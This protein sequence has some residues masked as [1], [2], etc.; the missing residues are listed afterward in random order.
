M[1]YFIIR[2]TDE[3]TIDQRFADAYEW[4]RNSLIAELH[5]ID[6]VFGP[7]VDAATAHERKMTVESECGE[8]CIVKFY[9]TEEER[10][11][12]RSRERLRF[13]FGEYLPVP[14]A[15]CARYE[16]RD[17]YVHLSRKTPGMIAYTQSEEHGVK[18]RQTTIRP[19]RY[20]HQFYPEWTPEA[21]DRYCGQ[22]NAN[23]L[24]L[25]ITNDPDQIVAVY[26]AEH[27]PNSC[28][29]HQANEY[30]SSIHPVYVYG[31]KYSDLALA[32]IGS[33]DTGIRARAIVWPE[34][35]IHSRIYGDELLMLALLTSKKYHKGSIAGARI[36]ALEDDDDS[37]IMPYVDGIDRARLS[38][39]GKSIIL[40][41]GPICTTNTE[42]RSRSRQR[43]PE[44]EDCAECGEQ[45]DTRSENR[46]MIRRGF[47]VC[48]SCRDDMHHECVID[49]CDSEWY[50]GDG[51]NHGTDGD[52][53]ADC[54]VCYEKCESCSD[55]TAIDSDVCD[56]C[57][58]EMRQRCEHTM[59]LPLEAPVIVQIGSE[60]DLHHDFDHTPLFTPIA[61]A[62]SFYRFELRGRSGEANDDPT[63][64][65]WTICSMTD[66]SDG[67]RTC[68]AVSTDLALIVRECDRLSSMYPERVY[69]VIQF[70]PTPPS[71]V[72]VSQIG[73]A[74]AAAKRLERVA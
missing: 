63:G 51:D 37:W 32:Y 59:P 20:L 68:E 25:E 54:A 28:M 61:P 41:D 26:T 40:G 56:E 31:G 12:W 60:A 3:Q 44:F 18:D 15:N 69:R 23:G 58:E 43:D 42:G 27:A 36:T 24:K 64:Q 50:D 45:I 72:I 6:H 55:Y 67:L 2:K 5:S 39:D 49:T 17:H 57:G 7:I 35:K 14:W 62:G 11:D 21:I 22:C 29:R 48:E 73:A 47:H 65:Q 9:A 53:C 8:P 38:R 46:H 19:G 70:W 71:Q 30:D 52:L 74:N 66:P 13:D 4:R 16:L 33:I 34:K 1:P 10:A